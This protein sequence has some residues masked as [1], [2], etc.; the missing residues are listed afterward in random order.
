MDNEIQKRVLEHFNYIKQFYHESQILGV[1]AYGSMNYGTYI[2]GIS[3]VDTKAILIPSFGDLILREPISKEIHLANGE[4]CEVKDIR[5]LV[6]MFKKQNIN[7][8]EIL[9]TDYC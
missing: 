5:E 1:F 3:D 6:K 7:F 8:L 4:H 9:Y 2:K